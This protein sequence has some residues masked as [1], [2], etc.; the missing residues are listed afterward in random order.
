MQVLRYAETRR[1]R[2]VTDSYS[3]EEL[4]EVLVRAL[5]EL[6]A[7]YERDIAQSGEEMGPHVMYPELLVP[8][9]GALLASRKPEAERDLLRVFDFLED[10]L[11]DPDSELASV[12]STSVAPHFER[13]RE[14]LTRAREFMG[15][16]M[17]HATRDRLP[18]RIPK[19]LR[20]DPDPRS[21]T[22]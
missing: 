21:T 3:Y 7:N 17:L 2:P 11:A 14:V 20:K 15:P 8:Y 10:A 1:L 12:V 9:M 22:S 19:R 6:R 5:P 18:Y 4:N 13:D 16:R